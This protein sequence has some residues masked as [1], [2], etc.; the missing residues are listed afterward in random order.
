MALADAFRES[1]LAAFALSADRLA[2]VPGLP[3]AGAAALAIVLLAGLAEAAGESVV[4]FVNRVRP[5]RFVLSLLVSALIFAFTYLFLAGSVYAVAHL[6]IGP[7]VPLLTVTVM[8]GVA[9][10]PRMLGFLAFLP[11]FGQPLA[12]VL[13]GWSVLALLAGVRATMGASLVQA[14]AAVAL[15]ALLLAV[16]QRTVGRPFV[17]VATR[18]RWLT[19]G[20]RLATP[21]EAVEQA[22]DGEEA[23]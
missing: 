13:H 20:V 9:Y 23:G 8:V 3:R 15:G 12:L 22:L 10:A 4:L 2:A 7:H 21:Q 11:Y 19:A 16:L 1:A 17:Y 5:R 14:L 18:L 6:V